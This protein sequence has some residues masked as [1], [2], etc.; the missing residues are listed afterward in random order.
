MNPQS[1]SP[2]VKGSARRRLLRG[3]FA[4]P[5]VLMLSSGSALAAKSATCLAKETTSPSTAPLV[6]SSSLDTLMRVKLR[7]RSDYNVHFVARED[8]GGLN[9]ALSLWSTTTKWQKFGV[10]TASPDK[11]NKLYDLQQTTNLPANSQVDL[12]VALRFDADGN[13]VGMG[14]SGSGSV[15]GQSCWTS[16]KTSAG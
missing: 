2:S 7:K 8:L 16:I 10:S 15:I 11:Y 14:L 9:I 6:S 13:V 3:S 12:F 4:A 1:P 5:A